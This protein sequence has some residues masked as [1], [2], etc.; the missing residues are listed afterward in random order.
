MKLNDEIIQFFR[1]QLSN[2]Y[3]PKCFKHLGLDA[4]VKFL[5][6]PKNRFCS[7][8]HSMLPAWH[9]VVEQH[10]MFTFTLVRLL[11]YFCR[12]YFVYI[13]YSAR[14]DSCSFQFSISYRHLSSVLSARPIE[15][16]CSLS[17]RKFIFYIPLS[18]RR[19]HLFLMRH[20]IMKLQKVQSR[21]EMTF[22]H[23][24]DFKPL[25]V[26][27]TKLTAGHFFR[28]DVSRWNPDSIRS[29][30]KMKSIEH[31]Y[32]NPIRFDRFRQ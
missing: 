4:L 5:L 27:F 21:M 25:G 6:V 13:K 3:K 31:I 12:T 1:L 22:R 28:S 24:I 16:N 30:T 19:I 23:I 11:R 15:N 7:L 10:H 26:G 29:V 20:R 9:G 32:F 8:I 2:A 14:S 17:H 18:H